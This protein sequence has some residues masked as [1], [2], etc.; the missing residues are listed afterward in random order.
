VLDVVLLLV[1]VVLVGAVIWLYL[2]KAPRWDQY[3][4]EPRP[5]I[6]G[7]TEVPPPR[8]SIAVADEPGDPADAEACAAEGALF[9]RLIDGTL[10]PPDYRRAMAALAAAAATGQPI[11]PPHDRDGGGEPAGT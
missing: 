2:N 10:T 8:S 5:A 7:R 6:A 11:E 9:A 1:F 3:D 4:G